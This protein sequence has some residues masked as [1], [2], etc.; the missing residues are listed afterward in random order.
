MASSIDHGAAPSSGAR[1]RSLGLELRDFR[2]QVRTSIDEEIR[3]YPTPIPRCDAQF[4]FVYEQRAQLSR[5][6]SGLDAALERKDAPVPLASAMADF[7]RARSIGESGEEQAL[8]D[9]I[10][11]A[12]SA[13]SSRRAQPP[14]APAGPD[15]H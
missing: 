12:L 10:A 6:L 3:A 14:A 5:W 4:N 15:V 8:R 7:C 2:L 13:E 9:R 11:A 1:L